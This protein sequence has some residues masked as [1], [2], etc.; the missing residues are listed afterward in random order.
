MHGFSLSNLKYMARFAQAW[1]E[2]AIGQQLVDQLPWGQNITLITKLHDRT[3]PE[4]PNELAGLLPSIESLTEQLDAT[5]IEM[6]PEEPD[7]K[8]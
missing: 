6:P 7:L 8:G 5:I 2:N 4:L 1:P 3:S